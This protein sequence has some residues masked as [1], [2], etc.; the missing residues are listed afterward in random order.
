MSDVSKPVTF[1]LGAHYHE[2]L[3]ELGKTQG[4]SPGEFARQ[5]VTVALDG[6]DN[7]EMLDAVATLRD[8]ID[9]LRDDLG[10]VLG[11]VLVNVADFDK[12]QV[13][14][15]LTPRFGPRRS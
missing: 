14:E 11:T 2:R 12:D 8:E 5:L 15:L 3:S 4:R 10:W 13:R 7:R 6:G 1:R 9:S